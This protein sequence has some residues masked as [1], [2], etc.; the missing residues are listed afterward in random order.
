MTAA[1]DT[2]PSRIRPFDNSTLAQLPEYQR[3][4]EAL[5]YLV[6]AAYSTKTRMSQDQWLTAVRD[7]TAAI[8]FMDCCLDCGRATPPA[9]LTKIDNSGWMQPT[10]KCHPCNNTWT[11]G[12]STAAPNHL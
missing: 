9:A 12:W 3:A 8:P 10:Y 1:R 6:H 11:C 4:A 7:L 5:N 2:N